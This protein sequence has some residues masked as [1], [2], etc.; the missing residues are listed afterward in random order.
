MKKVIA[1]TIAIAL[2]MMLAACQGAPGSSATPTPSATS[3]SDAPDVPAPQDWKPTK[4]VMI[5]NPYKAGG[6]GDLEVKALQPVIEK[7]LG[8][9]LVTEYLTTGGGVA[10]LEKVFEADPD[11]YTLVYLN[12]PA[13]SISELTDTVNYKTL[14]FTFLQN[15]ST[16]YRCIATLSSGS[17]KTVEDMM[18]AAQ[19]GG[20]TIA[21]S[22]IGSS[23]HLQTLLVEKACEIDLNDVP[24]EGTSA[25]KAAFL[26]G[27]VDLWAIDAV[28]VAPLVKSGEVTVLAM[29]APER[30]Q[31]LPDV[32][33]FKE[34]GFDGVEVSTARGF[35]APPNL[36]DD[37]KAGLIKAL[38]AAV[39]S[40]EMLKYAENVGTSLNPVSGD[41]YRAF[42]ANTHESIAAISNLFQ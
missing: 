37:V 18:K 33:T 24:F 35:V 15:V 27:H 40:D 26:G 25:A 28:T 6:A 39:N 32:P 1:L 9:S 42:T 21:H 10:A 14:D 31:L 12:N 8:Q 13:A 2:V 29:C 41:D 5:I 7:E 38:N 23:G 4:P 3:L 30:H 17:I 16:E 20:V 19:A 22:G 11:G 36:P 34:A